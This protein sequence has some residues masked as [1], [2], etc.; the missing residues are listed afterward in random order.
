MPPVSGEVTWAWG[1]EMK[2][3]I[4]ILALVVPVA[5]KTAIYQC[6]VDGKTVFTDRPCSGPGH[7]VN[8]NRE[9]EMAG[10]R[11]QAI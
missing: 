4:L 7:E 6:L 9:Y 8:V 10:H 2:V 5:G 3:Q 1:I 11:S